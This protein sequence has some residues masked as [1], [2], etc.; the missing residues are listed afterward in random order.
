VVSIQPGHV[1][2]MEAWSEQV[3]TKITNPI[4]TRSRFAVTATHPVRLEIAG[5]HGMTAS[6]QPGYAHV[7]GFGVER[8]ETWMLHAISEGVCPGD[9]PCDPPADA[10][11]ALGKEEIV[12]VTP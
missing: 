10:K 9:A 1:W 6:L 2:R 12:A 11:L 5:T 4:T 7:E 3:T 8:T